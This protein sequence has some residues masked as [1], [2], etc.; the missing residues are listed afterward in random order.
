MRDR[1]DSTHEASAPAVSNITWLVIV[2]GGLFVVL[3][4]L[5]LIFS[6]INGNVP[7]EGDYYKSRST[8]VKYRVE[9]VGTKAELSHYYYELEATTSHTSYEKKV[10]TPSLKFNLLEGDA[11]PETKCVAFNNLESIH[12]NGNTMISQIL[13]VPLNQLDKFTKVD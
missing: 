12:E 2:F 6:A 9:K 4:L 7:D 8:G 13:F 11:P 1:N 3:F 5:G 10:S